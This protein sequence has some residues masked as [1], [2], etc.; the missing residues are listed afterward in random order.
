PQLCFL[1][2]LHPETLDPGWLYQWARSPQFLQQLGIYKDQTDMAPYVSL[3]DMRRVRMTLP[4]VEEQRRIA[5]ALGAFDE[6]IETNRQ[7]AAS[8]DS[9]VATLFRTLGTSQPHVESPFFEVFD[10]DFGAAFKGEYFS[11]AG[12]GM[13]L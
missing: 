6:L 11:P 13:P 7:L 2:S 4:R 9:Q 8:L 3:T 5:A 12:T 10:V 1:R